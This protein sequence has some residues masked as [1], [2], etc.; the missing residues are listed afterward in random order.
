MAITYVG[1][2]TPLAA[3]DGGVAGLPAGTQLNDILL[4]VAESESSISAPANWAHIPGSP[5]LASFAQ[6]SVLWKRATVSEIAPTIDDT[7]NH[8]FVVIFGFRGVKKTGDPWNALSTGINDSSN[9]SLTGTVTTVA[10]CQVVI[11]ASYGTDTDVAI[12]TFSNGNLTGLAEIF[13]GGTSLG[14]GGG[15]GVATGVKTTAGDYG[16]TTISRSASTNTGWSTIALEPS[17]AGRNQ[18]QVLA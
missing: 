8:Q 16:T 12:F 4:M 2:G 6:H 7:G 15:I 5:M 18:A 11:T 14:N 10:G 9:N 17:L 13:D 3:V 1:A